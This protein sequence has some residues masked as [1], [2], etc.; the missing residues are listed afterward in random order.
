[1][2]YVRAWTYIAAGLGHDVNGASG[3]MAD[4]SVNVRGQGK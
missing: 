1:M 2:C 4:F 3:A